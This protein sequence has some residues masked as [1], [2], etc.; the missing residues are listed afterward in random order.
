[1]FVLLLCPAALYAQSGG[2]TLSDAVK[3]ALRQNNE[4]RSSREAVKGAQYDVDSSYGKYMPQVSVTG[5]ATRLDGPIQIDL[6]QIRTAI[7]GASGYTL[8]YAGGTPAQV[9]AL[10]SALNSGL[11]SFVDTVQDEAFYNLTLKATQPIYTGGKLTANTKAKNAALAMAQNNNASVSDTVI[12]NVVAGYY[13]LQ[14]MDH[15]VQIRQEVAD[16]MKEHDTNAQRLFDQGM[17]SKANRLRAGVALAE[18]ERE[19]AKAHRD[20]ELSAILLA[21]LLSADA[22]TFTLTTNFFMAHSM[23]SQEEMENKALAANK[24]LITLDRAHDQLDAK[25]VAARANMLPTVYAFG[26]YELYR[27]DLTMLMPNWAAGLGM[28]L[29]LFSGLSDYKDMRSA[30]A[31]RDKLSYLQAN[32]RELVKTEVRKHYH[33]MLTARDQYESLGKS[34]ELAEENLR[35]NRLAFDQGVATSLE[36]VDAQLALGKVKIDRYKALF[37][38]VDALASLL[39]AGGS[40]PAILDYA[41]K[42]DEKI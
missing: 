19:L 18:A 9:A 20:S 16:G 32:A 6:T 28:Q 5:S 27:K 40:A 3:T 31:E 33:D 17:I 29:S 38:Y 26:Q 24:V 23:P 13:R 15:V 36:V 30:D 4:I 7:I 22:S 42:G 14:L 11:P 39:R 35:L 37:D 34:V 12:A 25:Y 8:A 41:E 1:M 10:Q 21:N 2:M